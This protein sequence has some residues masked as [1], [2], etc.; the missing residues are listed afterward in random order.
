MLQIDAELCRINWE[1]ADGYRNV[2]AKYPTDRRAIG[3]SQKLTLV[4]YG[5]TSLR[6]TEMPFVV[7]Q[8]L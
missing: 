8:P 4:P 7:K 2:P 5:C 1:M 6:M 3:E